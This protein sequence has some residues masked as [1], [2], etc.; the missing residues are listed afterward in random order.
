MKYTKRAQVLL[1][2]KQYN[3]LL[4]HAKEEHLSLGEFLRDWIERE[5]ISQKEKEQRRS[6][7]QELLSGKFSTPQ[8]FDHTPW[9][10][11]YEKIKGHIH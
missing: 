9:K 2:P 6:A 1:T 5:F 8:P 11:E 4:A 10:Q 3:T 7:V